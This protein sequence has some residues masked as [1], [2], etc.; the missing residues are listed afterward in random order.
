[1]LSAKADTLQHNAKPA[2]VK[3]TRT[4]RVMHTLTVL[5]S[6]IVL[7]RAISLPK[8]VQQQ[9]FRDIFKLFLISRLH[10]LTLL[11]GRACR[12]LVMFLGRFLHNVGRSSVEVRLGVFGWR[13]LNSRWLAPNLKNLC[14]GRRPSR[15]GI[16]AYSSSYLTHLFPLRKSEV[17]YTSALGR[18]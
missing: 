1:M 16:C 9:T 18:A 5:R 11:R 4:L 17:I 7:V 15:K 10:M 12:W 6:K 14:S 2:K 8:L 13:N 3:K